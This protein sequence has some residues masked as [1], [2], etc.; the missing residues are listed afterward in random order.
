M[1]TAC[2][3]HFPQSSSTGPSCGFDETLLVFFRLRQSTER[4]RKTT[5]DMWNKVSLDCSLCVKYIPV[6]SL[7]GLLMSLEVLRCFWSVCKMRIVWKWRRNQKERVHMK[8]FWRWRIC[9]AV[10]LILTSVAALLMHKVLL[11]RVNLHEDCLWWTLSAI[12]LTRSKL[13][14]WRNTFGLLS[15]EAVYRKM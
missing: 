2:D 14:L 9:Y 15:P 3:E 11:T 1:K 6:W 12:K 5:Y 8:F 10:F 13:W 7:D 4:C